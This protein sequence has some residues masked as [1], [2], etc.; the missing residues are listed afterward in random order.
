MCVATS[1]M[2]SACP[3]SLIEAQTIV[4]RSFILANA[5][6]KHAPLG[7]DFC[8]DDCCQRY[9]GMEGLTLQSI[10]GSENSRGLVPVFDGFI[11]DTRYS[12]SCGGMMESFSAVWGG[13]NPPYFQVK[14]DTVETMTIPDLSDENEF[15]RWIDDPPR[16]FCSPNYIPENELSQYLGSV[17]EDSS[18]YRWRIFYSQEELTSLIAAKSQRSLKAVKSLKPLQRGGSGRIIKLEIQA[19]DHE[20]KPVTFTLDSEYEIRRHLHSG[21]LYSSAFYV[22]PIP[23]GEYPAEFFILG[24]GWGHGA[25]LCQIGALGMSLAAYRSSE[26]IKHYYPGVTL[27][28]LYT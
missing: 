14:P 2:G 3:Q 10:R 27:Q 25:G 21:F 13:Q 17:D 22:T 15:R 6:K 18:Y 12:K 9:H 1:E 20:H 16:A 28:R 24:G 19:L 7:F 4:A 8:N 5:E 23:N 26:I 11:C